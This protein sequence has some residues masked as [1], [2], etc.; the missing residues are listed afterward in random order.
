[1]GK[2]KQELKEVYAA[3]S[4]SFGW[5]PNCQNAVEAI[6][7]LHN[8]REAGITALSEHKLELNHVRHFISLIVDVVLRGTKEKSELRIEAL[9]LFKKMGQIT[10]ITPTQNDGGLKGT[11]QVGITAN[12]TA[13][14]PVV[15][16]L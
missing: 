3:I 11:G 13:T 16:Q 8:D 5:P 6:K 15:P 12:A 2:S 14:A 1:M 9:D 7:W 10:Y 4:V